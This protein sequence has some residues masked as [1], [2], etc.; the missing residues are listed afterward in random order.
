MT[1]IN[2]INAKKKE[3]FLTAAFMAL[4]SMADRP[5]GYVGGWKEA[6]KFVCIESAKQALK[7]YIEYGFFDTSENSL[8]SI[9]SLRC[10]GSYAINTFNLFQMSADMIEQSYGAKLN[11]PAVKRMR[12]IILS[13]V[14]MIDHF[15]SNFNKSPNSKILIMEKGNLTDR[16][17]FFREAALQLMR[18]QVNQE[19]KFKANQLEKITTNSMAYAKMFTDDVFAEAEKLYPV[20]KTNEA[21]A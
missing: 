5:G 9:A 18:I 14:F 11:P 2:F 10:A 17:V 4:H 1:T 20:D 16:Q 3:L 8:S 21:Q 13:T 19:L 12:E 15:N 6:H 7:S